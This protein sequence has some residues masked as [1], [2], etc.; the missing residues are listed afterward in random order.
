MFELSLF[1]TGN[2]KQDLK[3]FKNDIREYAKRL[4][5]EMPKT[6]PV[7]IGNEESV[8]KNIL[9][10]TEPITNKWFKSQEIT[11]TTNHVKTLFN[12]FFITSCYLIPKDRISVADIKDFSLWITRLASL[13][14]PKLIVILGEPAAH[15]FVRR[16][17]IVKENHGKRI[18][19]WKD[20][21]IYLT[22]PMSYYYDRS[23][24]EDTSYKDYIKN[25]DW[26]IFKTKF[27]E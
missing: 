23:E 2:L 3:F 4:K 24:Y 1:D 18:A 22:Y 15:V 8:G 27:E 25:N 9:V 19:T 16:K 14:R 26:S 12:D 11:R 7:V 13:L 10:I 5:I 6:F 21:P 20:I 17:A